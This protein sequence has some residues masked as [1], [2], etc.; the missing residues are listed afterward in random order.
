MKLSI[1]TTPLIALLTATLVA[2]SDNSAPVVQDTTNAPYLVAV[3]NPLHYF[4]QRLSSGAVEVRLPAPAGTDPAPWAPAVEDVLQ[5][6]GAELV[7]LNGAGYSQWPGKVTLSAS[8]LVVTSES[9]RDQWIELEG[10]V[11]HSHGP[12]GE[13]AHGGYAITT[14][15]DFDIAAGQAESIAEALTAALPEEASAIAERLAAL[16]TDL[17]ELD[18]AWQ[19]CAKGLSGKALI[20]SHPVYQYFEQRYGLAGTSLHWEPDQMPSDE[21]WRQLQANLVADALFVWES[22]PAPEI[23]SKMAGIGLAS[24]VIDPAANRADQDWLAVQQANLAGVEAYC[25]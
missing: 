15:M 9:A 11:T 13:H 23:S 1:K 21:Q 8:K 2:C 4:S 6:Q 20:Y 22:E 19:R 5:L 25:E 16:Q 3:N 12:E 7:L 18:L 24:V 14:W 10:Q 17:T